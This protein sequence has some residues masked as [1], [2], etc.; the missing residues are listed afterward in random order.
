MSGTAHDESRVA[1]AYT[2]PVRR[3]VRD[4]HR[5]D[6]VEAGRPFTLT[7]LREGEQRDF[8]LKLH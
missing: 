3:D 4:H 2:L 5:I 1:R 7:V 6:A 8:E